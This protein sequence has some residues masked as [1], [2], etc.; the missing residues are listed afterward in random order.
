[1]IR[2]MPKEEI[3]DIFEKEGKIECQ[4]NYCG[5]QYLFTKNDIGI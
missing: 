3:L 1:M 4:C 2:Q 5:K